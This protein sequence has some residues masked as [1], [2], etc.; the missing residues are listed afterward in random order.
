MK[1]SEL[2]QLVKEVIEENLS[3]YRLPKNIIDNQ[4][5]CCD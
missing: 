2:R 3:F 5:F 1:K 4:L